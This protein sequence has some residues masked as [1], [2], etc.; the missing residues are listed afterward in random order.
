MGLNRGIHTAIEGFTTKLFRL[1]DTSSCYSSLMAGASPLM[2]SSNVKLPLPDG[3]FPPVRLTSAEIEVYEQRVEIIMKNALA[4]YNLHEAMGARPDY[5]ARWSIVGNVEHLTAI[6]ESDPSRAVETSRIFGRVDGDYRNFIDFFYSDTAQQVFAVN[7]F[8]LGCAVDAAV[9]CN[10][11]TKESNKPHQYLGMK[12]VCLQ[13]STL[14]RKRDM[15]FLEYLVYTKDLQGRN[16]GVRITL[17]LDLKECPPLPDKLK[18]R[19]THSHTVTI[20]RP[21]REISDASHIFMTSEA[22]MYK[23]SGSSSIASFKKVMITLSS[24]ALF[25]DSKRISMHGMLDRKSWVPKKARSNCHVC[26]RK[27]STTRR[28]QHCR[29]CGEVACRRCMTIRAAPMVDDSTSL[30]SRTFQ[31]AKTVFCKVCMG[32]VRDL[33]VKSINSQ[34][35]DDKSSAWFADKTYNRSII[36]ACCSTQNEESSLSSLSPSNTSSA[37]SNSPLQETKGG[38]ERESLN[39]IGVDVT[40]SIDSEVQSE[41]KTSMSSSLDDEMEVEVVERVD[42]ALIDLRHL[43]TMA[44]AERVVQAVEEEEVRMMRESLAALDYKD[45]RLVELSPNEDSDSD[46]D[47][48]SDRS[49]SFPLMEEDEDDVIEILGDSSMTVSTARQVVSSP[50]KEIPINDGTLEH[51]LFRSPRENITIDQRLQEQEV[52]LKRLVMAANSSAGYKPPS[53]RSQQ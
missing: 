51:I 19:R 31:V 53:I 25:A 43:R 26:T 17:P 30:Y 35:F 41:T 52:L 20:V 39:L 45:V 37:R 50:R 7:Q 12:W 23:G 1:S 4:E 36:M 48:L 47:F 29:L 24:M 15:C 9:L 11:H 21:M 42:R 33:D 22:E 32:K 3:Y 46:Y 40:S 49:A 10:I 14:S 34:Y 16:V 38:E 5:G 18:T 13:S 2:I 28:K 8:M 6:R 44:G 27:F